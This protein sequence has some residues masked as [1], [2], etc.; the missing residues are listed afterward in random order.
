MKGGA[1]DYI[2]K[3]SDY[4]EQLQRVVSATGSAAEQ[5]TA[6]IRSPYGAII[7][8]TDEMLRLRASVVRAAASTATVLI[9]GETGTGKELVAR[10]I[11]FASTR[12][13]KPYVAVNCA[14]I[15]E[16]LFESEFFGSMRGAFTGA[17]ADRKGLL[18]STQGGT[19]VLDE[20]EALASGHQAKLLRVLQTHE[21]KPVGSTRFL[22]FDAR[23]IAA[24]NQDLEQ[25]VE[26]ERFRRDL[27]YRLD[28]LR[29]RVPALRERGQDVTLLAHHFIERFNC[30]NGTRYGE[31]SERARNA[32]ENHAWPGNVRELENLIERM[33]V[34]SN[35]DVID[36]TEVL[37]RLD[38]QGAGSGRDRVV[39]AL[40]RNRWNRERTARD[41]GISRVTLWRRMSRYG[42][43]S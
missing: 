38:R 21:F 3:K 24:S 33:L 31:F 15:P 22:R 35:D 2:V 9:E 23:V 8:D 41:L 34:N 1:V 28:V 11:H 14:E 32:L 5:K 27:F 42:I 13:K 30:R 43:R 36:E 29:I 37:A 7:G 6:E 20:I 26:Q 19:L 10:A 16:H 25:L 4:L 17:I 39:E 12:A 18:E 40:A